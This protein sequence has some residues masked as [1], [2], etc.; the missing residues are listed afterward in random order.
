MLSGNKLSLAIIHTH[1]HTF[2]SY[3]QW[4]ESLHPCIKC[5]SHW[6]RTCK[7]Q[8]TICWEHH[9]ILLICNEI[10][11]N[12]QISP[13]FIYSLILNWIHKLKNISNRSIKYQM[14]SSESFH[15]RSLNIFHCFVRFIKRIIPFRGKFY[16][17][18]L[19]HID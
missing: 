5:S 4:K 7:T 18:F 6:K 11:G 16:T 14:F 15:H 3:H 19:N 9:N 8:V 10:I 13:Q 17:L 12:P 2:I 1:T